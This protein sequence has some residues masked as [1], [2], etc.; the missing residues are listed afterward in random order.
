MMDQDKSKLKKEY[1]QLYKELEEILFRHD[2]MS[3]NFEVNEDEY[4][5]EVGTILPRLKDAES[6]S[7]VLDI[8]LE[9][10][11]RWFDIAINNKQEDPVFNAIAEEIWSAWQKFNKR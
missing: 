2:P 6:K 8:V 10:F 9:E 1:Q 3:I 5:P 7:D 4:S 11:K